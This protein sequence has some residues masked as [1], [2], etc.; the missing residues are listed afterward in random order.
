MAGAIHALAFAPGPLPAWSLPFVQILCL[1]FLADRGFQAPTVRKAAWYGFVFGCS[2]FCVGLYWLFISMHQFGGMP[3]PAAALG[4]LLLSMAMAIYGALALALSRWLRKP[5]DTEPQFLG[6]LFLSSATFAS[7]WALFEWL[8]GTLFTGFPWLN[9]GYAH[10]DGMFA[11]WAPLVG[12][13]GLAWLAA[14]AAA[15][16]ALFARTRRQGADA[17]ASVVVA[18]AIILGMVGVSL[19][20][21]NWASAYGDPIIVRLVQGNVPQSQKFDPARMQQGIETY[22]YL[23]GLPAKAPGS[24]PDIIILP[25]TVVPVFQNRVPPDFWKGW[26]S[27]AARNNATL[28][29]GVPIHRSEDN[30]N[31]YTNSVI[32]LDASTSLEQLIAGK[33]DLRYDKHHLVPFGEFIPTGFR[34]FVDLM[35]IPLGDFDR[36][37]LGQTPFS[38]SGQRIAMNICYEDVFGEEIVG[39]VT[40]TQNSGSS[41]TLL[42]N[43]SNLAWFGDSWALRQHLQ[44]ARVRALETAR[45]MLR[46]TNTG[47]TAAIDANGAVRAALEPQQHGVLDVQI[48]GTTGTTPYARWGNQPTLLFSMMI[49][50]LALGRR[51]QVQAV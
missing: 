29:M 11:H 13:Y 30:R 34:W 25:E 49:L 9:I 24:E 46:A 47:A 20:R 51:K 37:A 8:R 12:V 3:A 22:Q 27:I 36:G 33:P 31:V 26:Q 19:G 39:A 45:P 2:N 43:V 28:I 16:V 40:D 14:F 50:G 32:G 7:A 21:I 44:I 17:R 48:Q 38:V 23:A 35:S 15:A 10:V 5:S 4:V 6:A 1:A 18:A 41:A 42:V